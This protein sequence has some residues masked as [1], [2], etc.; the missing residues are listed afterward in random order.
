MKWGCGGKRP[1]RCHRPRLLLI[2]VTHPLSQKLMAIYYDHC[3]TSLTPFPPFLIISH[4]AWAWV[5]Y[6]S[7]TWIYL[8]D[9]GNK[10]TLYPI[11]VYRALCAS[12]V[13]TRITVKQRLIKQCRSRTFGTR[14]VCCVIQLAWCYLWKGF[15]M[16]TTF[17]VEGC[18]SWCLCCGT[19]TDF[20]S[21]FREGCRP[22]THF[23]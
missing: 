1:S 5:I 21:I 17:K 10:L 19:R 15:G 14:L 3:N 12:S 18:A 8:L 16:T 4:I 11:F 20:W 2:P 22:T 7:R 6:S 9:Q 13:L 23:F